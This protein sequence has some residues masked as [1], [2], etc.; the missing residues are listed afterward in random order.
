M[1]DLLVPTDHAVLPEVRAWLARPKGLFIDGSWVD[2]A[3]GR[4]FETRDPATGEVLTQVAH[5]EAEDVDRAVRAARRAFEGEWALWT[6]AQRQR[7]LFKIGEAVYDHAEELAQLESLDNGKSAAVAQAVDITWVAELFQYYAGWATKIEGRTLPVS[8]PWAPGAQWHAYTLREPVGVCGA[9]VPWNFPLLMAAFKVPVALTCGNTVVLKPAEDTPL[10]ALR[11]A[12]IM[13][14]CGLPDG[15]FNVVTGYGE[16]G[17]ALAAHDDVDKIAFTG[18]TEVGKLIVDAAKGNLKKVSLELGGKSPQVVFADADLDLAIPGTASGFLFNQGQTC[19]SGTRLLVEDRIFDEF[20]QGVAEVAA[21]SKVGPGLDPTTDVGPL[22]SQTQLDRVLGYVDAGL[23]DGARALTGGRRHGDAGY[24]VE[25]TVLVDV[26]SSFSVYR[27]EIFGPVVVATPFNAER[28]V[29]A[30][31]N[32]TPYGLAASVWTRDVSKAHRTARQIKA[33]TVWINC[34]NAFD[35]AMPF[36]GYKQ[37][38][39]GRELGAS[40][41]DAYTE[42]KSVNALLT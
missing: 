6:P 13:A 27:E 18:S 32:D 22:V 17:A 23:R 1:T 31:A 4:T 34:H 9:I 38:G 16:A 20:T 25:P 26:D 19:T 36:G 8:V 30:A 2:A 11:L 39:W 15:V 29:A 12:E 7:L 35:T 10:T 42:Q 37:S 40:A 21:A 3:S 5:G 24:Y 33:G 28:G 41:I 14:E